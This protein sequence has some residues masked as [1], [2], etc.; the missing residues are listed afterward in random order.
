MVFVT[1][2]APSTLKCALCARISTLDDV[3]DVMP[4]F[5]PGEK[6]TTTKA[7]REDKT[8]DRD[9]REE[10]E[11][12]EEEEEVS[13][14]VVVVVALSIEGVFDDDESRWNYTRQRRKKGPCLGFYLFRV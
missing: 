1:V 3:D 4:L 12:G 10:E 11:D 14:N 5:L 7:F 2:L 6:K 9:S 8:L 13:K